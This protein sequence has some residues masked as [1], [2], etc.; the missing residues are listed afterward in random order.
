MGPTDKSVNTHPNDGWVAM[1]SAKDCQFNQ[2]EEC[3]APNIR[4]VKHV[5]HAD[6]GTYDPRA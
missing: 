4:V 3:H 6:C 2:Q 1:C 5:D